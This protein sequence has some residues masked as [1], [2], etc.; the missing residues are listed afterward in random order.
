MVCAD[1][2]EARAPRRHQSADRLV[3]AV[4][5]AAARVPRARRRAKRDPCPARARPDSLLLA[6]RLARLGTRVDS[7][8]AVVLDP[9]SRCAAAALL[10]PRLGRCARAAAAPKS[11]ALLPFIRAAA[12]RTRSTVAIGYAEAMRRLCERYAT[13]RQRRFDRRRC[14]ASPPTARHPRRRCRCCVPHMHTCCCCAP[15][16]LR[17]AAVAAAAAAAM[18]EPAA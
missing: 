13:Y 18:A 8:D 17:A 7:P 1:D 10:R 9:A 11:P 16:P 3:R 12:I 4:R 14:A 2:G 15:P 6:G 5:A